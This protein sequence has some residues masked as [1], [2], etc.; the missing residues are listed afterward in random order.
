MCVRLI[1][2][3]LSEAGAGRQ[4]VEREGV[5]LVE[6]AKARLPWRLSLTRKLPHAF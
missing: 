1:A 3:R 4:L 6:F 5:M 2:P